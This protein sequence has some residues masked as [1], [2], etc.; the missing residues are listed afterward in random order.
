VLYTHLEPLF[1]TGG[2]PFTPASE[3]PHAGPIPK[4]SV[5]CCMVCHKSGKD[6]IDP[7]VPDGVVR[8]PDDPKPP[9]KPLT[10][11]KRLSRK[12]AKKAAR[13]AKLAAYY[14]AQNPSLN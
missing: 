14:A 3:C 5:F 13:K 4:G 6:G 10:P 7:A 11:E 2:V 12:A 1:P 8:L 9:E